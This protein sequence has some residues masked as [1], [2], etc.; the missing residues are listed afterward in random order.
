MSLVRAE[1]VDLLAR[2]YG[3]LPDA[4]LRADA[5]DLF[6]ITALLADQTTDEE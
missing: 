4:V 3:V 5:H 1:M 6:Q 2:R